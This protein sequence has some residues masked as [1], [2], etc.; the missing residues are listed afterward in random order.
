MT[1]QKVGV[2]S[3]KDRNATNMDNTMKGNALRVSVEGRENISPIILA[4]TVTN[5]I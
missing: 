3:W 2:T 1:L 5:W 4:L